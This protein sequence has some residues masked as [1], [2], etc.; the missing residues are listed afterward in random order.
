MKLVLKLC[1]SFPRFAANVVG[2]VKK[3]VDVAQW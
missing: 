1:L 2:V 3:E